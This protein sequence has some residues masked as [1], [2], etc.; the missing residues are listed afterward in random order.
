MSVLETRAVFQSIPEHAIPANVTEPDRPKSNRQAGTSHESKRKNDCRRRI[1]VAEVVDDGT[2]L[3]V[4]KITE[5]EDVWHQEQCWEKPP[6]LSL[7][8]KDRNA[9]GE[10]HGTF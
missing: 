10:E 3:R 7:R 5:H 1:R 2:Q 6:G 9:G 4:A 8:S